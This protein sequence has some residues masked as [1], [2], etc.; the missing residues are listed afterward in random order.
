MLLQLSKLH[1]KKKEN[2]SESSMKRAYATFSSIVGIA[3]NLLLGLTKIGVGFFS[4]SVAILADGFNNLSDAAISFLTLLGFQIA[5]YGRG[6]THPFGH[7]RFEWI[8]AIFTSLA[9]VLMG[10]KLV[11]ASFQSIANPAELQFSLAVV[12]V[13]LLS[14]LLKG[15]MYFYNRQF[16]KI[17]NSETLKATATDC[18]SDAVATGAVLIS[19]LVAYLTEWQI[20][21]YCGVLVSGFIIITGVKS[22]W[23]VLGRIMGRV[24]EQSVL[25]EIWQICQDR[26]GII[27]IEN[28]MVHDYGFGYFV[29]SLEI[30]GYRQNSG[31]LYTAS[32]EISYALYERFRCDCFVQ[33]AYLVDDNLLALNLQNKLAEFLQNYSDKIKI[34]RFRLI[35]SGSYT[36]IAFDLLYPAELQKNEEFICQE[37]EKKLKEENSQYRVMI[38][39]IL[40]R[41]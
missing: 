40:W 30:E 8:M 37:I 15:Y 22:L 31:Q 13:L 1:L 14:I 25:D 33:V 24:T 16:A 18:L 2:M 36:T 32:R 23:E 4:C 29:I 20:D 41:K 21:G 17:T 28:M 19:T 3:L 27:A 10:E 5:R 11:Q 6:K 38:K 12:I 9:V 7:G 39:S 34:N 26:P 35:E